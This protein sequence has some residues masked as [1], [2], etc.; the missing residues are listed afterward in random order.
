MYM[1]KFYHRCLIVIIYCNSRFG[2]KKKFNVWLNKYSII[3]RSP[4]LP[5]WGVG[6]CCVGWV[7]VAFGID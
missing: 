1:R 7:G 3:L 4:F 2:K 6:E 5:G